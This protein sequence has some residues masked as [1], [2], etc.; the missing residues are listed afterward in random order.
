MNKYYYFNKYREFFSIIKLA[1]PNGF[2]KEMDLKYFQLLDYKKQLD[3]VLKNITKK[4]TV[5]LT[6]SCAGNC[7]LTLFL[8]Y[9]YKQETDRDLHFT[10]LEIQ[11]RLMEEAQKTAQ[12]LNLDN[13]SFITAD[14]LT[15]E[16]RTKPDII[17][18]L[19]ACNTATDATIYLG[20]KAD[21]RYIL[22]VSCCQFSIKKQLKG[23]P[24]TAITKHGVYKDR[25]TDIIGD[26]LRALIIEQYNYKSDIFAFTAIKNT[27]KNIMLRATKIPKQNNRQVQAKE[28]FYDLQNIFNI[29]PELQN[30]L[31]CQN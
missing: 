6:E 23:H 29:E 4:R 12:K 2:Y 17:Y 16:H 13:I 5:Y 27:G 20:L 3:S 19:H 24:L 15:Y 10:C 25:L 28:Q 22:S 21:A 26:T 1:S 11:P 8:A 7:Y 31:I 18:S 9:I 14:V 30:L